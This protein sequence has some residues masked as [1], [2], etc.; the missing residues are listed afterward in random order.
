MVGGIRPTAWAVGLSRLGWKVDVMCYPPLRAR[1]DARQ[2]EF[3]SIQVH[4]LQEPGQASNA[5]GSST[6]QPSRVL[7]CVRGA[8]ERFSVPDL[9]IWK[10]RR[11]AGRAMAMCKSIN[12]DVILSSTP[13]HSLHWLA[14]KLAGKFDRPWIADFRDPYTIDR[15]F[16]HSSRASALSFPHRRFENRI[17]MRADM[18]I[19]AIPLHFRWARRFY[20]QHRAK[21]RFMPNGFPSELLARDQRHAIEPPRTQFCC[22]SPVPSR[23]LETICRRIQETNPSSTCKLVILGAQPSGTTSDHTIAGVAVSFRGRVSHHEALNLFR[24]AD[25]LVNYVSKDRQRGLGLSSKLFEFLALEKPILCINP[26]RSDRLLLKP[27]PR[28]VQIEEHDSFS[29]EE[30]IH[31]LVHSKFP[32]SRSRE[33][34]RSRY[35][36]DSQVDEVEKWLSAFA[37]AE[38][39]HI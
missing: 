5:P 20:P 12:P 19:H 13:Q 25:V 30:A 38:A 3:A 34:F 24:S 21:I 31:L 33:A 2:E 35:S 16:S 27:F 23:L 22:A 39:N 28:C 15:R 17:Y 6:H 26:T 37:T 36:R 29:I 11:H 4:Y 8:L 18:C 7:G 14:M 32:P 10:Q 1:L 9:L